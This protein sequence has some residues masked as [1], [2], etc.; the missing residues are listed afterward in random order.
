MLGFV[1]LMPMDNISLIPKER[2][3]KGLPGF[4][5]FRAPQI[6]L[7]SIAKMGLALILVSFLATGGLYAWK[8]FLNKKIV[9]LNSELQTVTGQ[10]DASLENRLQNLN[11]VLEIFKNV[12]DNHEYWTKFFGL[13]EE[14]TLNTVT[15]RSFDGDD[16][17]S[18]VV[19]DGSAPSYDVLARQIKIFEESEGIMSAAASSIALSETGRVNF[20]VKIVFNKDLIRKK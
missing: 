13:L 7:T 2:K 5:S 19:M 3:S 6:E 18:T 4:V 14:K 9:S 12:L 1:I 15:F 8:Y 20:T 11:S 16:A 17:A 10:R